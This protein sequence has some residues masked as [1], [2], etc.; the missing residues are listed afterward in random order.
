MV[1]CVRI[2]E[3]SILREGSKGAPIREG[4]LKVVAFENLSG[5]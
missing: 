2:S 5:C 3:P 1:F 4:A